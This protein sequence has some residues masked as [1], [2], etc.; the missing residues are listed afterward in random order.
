[1]YTWTPP[2]YIVPAGTVMII[3]VVVLAVIGIRRAMRS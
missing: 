1:M 2:P 3:L